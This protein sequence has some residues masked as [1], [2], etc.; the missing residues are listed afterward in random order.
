MMRIFSYAQIL[1]LCYTLLFCGGVQYHAVHKKYYSVMMTHDHRSD[2]GELKYIHICNRIDKVIFYF[3]ILYSE[4]NVLYVHLT[5]S[6]MQCNIYNQ[7]YCVIYAVS[8]ENKR[9]LIFVCL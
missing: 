1:F 5:Y 3:S 7:I 4:H 6:Y 9:I 8:G 2:P